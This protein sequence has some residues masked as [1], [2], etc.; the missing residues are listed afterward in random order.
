MFRTRPDQ[1][2]VKFGAQY[3]HESGK[4]DD[5]RSDSFKTLGQYAIKCGPVASKR[6]VIPR[7]QSLHPSPWPVS[8]ALAFEARSTGT[9]TGRAGWSPDHVPHERHHV[10]TAARYEDGDPPQKQLALKGNIVARNHPAYPEHPMPSFG[11][12]LCRG[13]NR[14]LRRDRN[15][16]DSGIEGSQQFRFGKTTR[17]GEPCKD[18]EAIPT[19]RDRF[20]RRDR[21]ATPAA[22]SRSSRRPVTCASPP[23]RSLP[24]G[25]DGTSDIEPGRLQQRLAQRAG[26]PRARII[27]GTAVLF[28]YPANQ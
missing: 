15:H 16:S 27:P 11:E 7:P 25:V 24:Q 14:R 6:T 8:A 5:V 17:F 1:R 20:R 22:R 2:L 21:R 13:V 23:Q 12:R 26:C 18:R 9:S 19:R 28:H 3:A 10:R 4:A